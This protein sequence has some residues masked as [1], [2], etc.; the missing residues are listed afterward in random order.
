MWSDERWTLA[1]LPEPPRLPFTAMLM[2]TA[3]LDLGDL[4]DEHAGELGRLIVRLD[5]AVRALPGVARMHVN[6]WGDGGAHLHVV[7]LARPAGM[8]QLRGSCLP[9][10]EDMLPPLPA[11]IAETNLYDVA[12]ALAEHSGRVHSSVTRA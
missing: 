4:D 9:L 7:L 10:W 5:R 6:K 12:S 8:A 1:R 11:E 3:H 2:P